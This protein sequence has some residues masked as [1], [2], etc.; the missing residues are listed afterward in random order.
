MRR[1]CIIMTGV[2]LIISLLSIRGYSQVIKEEKEE[3]VSALKKM[4]VKPLVSEPYLRVSV[5]AGY[6]SNADLTP[7]K[8]GDIFEEFLLSAGF[9]KPLI[10]DLKF[11]FDY[12][13]DFLNYNQFLDDTTLLNHF[14]LGLHQKI[15]R[16]TVGTG[17][18][19]GIFYY[20]HSDD[21]DFF[22]HKGFAYLRHDITRHLYHKLEAAYLYKNYTDRNALADTILTYQ[23]KHLVDN[24]YIL[25]YSIG[26]TPV[27]KLFLLAKARFYD[28]DSNARFQ[29]FYD[30]KSY[31]GYIGFDYALLKKLHLTGSASYERKNYNKRK[32]TLTNDREHDNLYTGNIGLRYSLNKN[33]AALLYYTYRDNASNEDLE[34]YRENIIAAGWQYSF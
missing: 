2:F 27:P 31:Y 25:E 9:A 8:K 10:K 21:D 7:L 22:A 12:D 24:R 34:A 29:N 15:S 32:V 13:L 28:N 26:A 23:N 4:Q 16:F 20:P 33:N 11:T 1:T 18:D 6:D 5:F 30:Y 17:Y 3:R 19:L 14:R